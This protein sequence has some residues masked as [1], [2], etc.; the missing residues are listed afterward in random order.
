MKK[1][2][3]ILLF[4]LTFIIEI[5]LCTILFNSI[6]S[7]KIDTVKVNECKKSIED[8]YNDINKY[9]TSLEYTV[10]DNEDNIVYK[11]SKSKTNSINESIMNN[12]IMVDIV[13][14]NK[15]VGKLLIN[16]NTNQLIKKYKSYILY[17]FI[18]MSIIQFIMILIYTLYLNKTIIKPFKDLN[19]FAS[20]VAEGNLDIPLYMD[21]KHT[22][23][24]FTEAFDLMR[25]ELKKARRNEKKANDDKKEMVAKL[26]HDI[27][28]PVASIKST[29]EIGYEV[30]NDDNIKKYFNSINI[31]TDQIKLLV[32]NLFN[33]SIN[34][35]TEIDVNPYNYNSNILNE[36][37]K[38][39]DYLNKLNTF[40]IPECTIF[41]DKVRM[42]QV[43]DNI[44]NNSYKYANTKI[45]IDI[46]SDK[47][48]LIIS[49]RDY[50]NG[51][52][53]LDIPFLKEKYRRG[54]DV[55][56]KDGAGL[57]LH[58]SDYFMEKMN[59]KLEISNDEP[60]FRVTI[61]IRII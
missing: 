46:K 16:N 61:Y 22:F 44:F 8:N 38:N 5:V 59:G 50:G 57:G 11:T 39:A 28:T 24:E 15:N 53:E 48:Y 6:K 25:S 18:T 58:L 33:S 21:K 30:S 1:R 54:S 51:V 32:D 17:L 40:N 27:K 12:D 29:S 19:R 49:I 20:R 52:N 45:D 56:D 7:V 60:G 43:F 3:G 37:I 23:G 26:S 31:K 2:I 47:D 14:D 34:E 13:I 42:Q 35:I 36:L 41:I 4:I 55:K 10:I 9:N